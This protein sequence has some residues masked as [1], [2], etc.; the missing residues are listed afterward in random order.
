MLE[1]NVWAIVSLLGMDHYFYRGITI[2]GTCRKFFLKNNV[3]QTIFSSD[4]VM[5]TIFYDHF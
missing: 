4:F 2:F 1:L 3:F 5:K